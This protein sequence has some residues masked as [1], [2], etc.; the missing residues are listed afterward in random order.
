VNEISTDVCVVGGGPAGLM[1]TLLLLRSGLRVA[2]AEK[3]RSFDREY[4]GEILQPGGLRV[5]DQVGALAGAKARGGYEM[6]RFQLVNGDQPV[7]DIDY[8]R[9]P[10]PHDY[11]L[12]LPQ[13]HLL[14]ELT[15]H[16]ERLPGFEMLSG[17]R[18]SALTYDGSTVTGLVADNGADKVTVRARCVVGADGRYSKVRS[19]AGITNHR[20]DVFDRDVL[21]FRLPGPEKQTRVVRIFKS[22]TSPAM[23]YDSYPN[24]LQ[25][26]WTVPHG[27]YAEV[28]AQGIEAVREA[29]KESLPDYADLIEEH[30]TSLK[31][32]KLLDVF[33]ARAER[34]AGDGVLLIGDAA[35]AHSPL[36]A[37]GINLALQ[38]AVLAHPILIGALRDGDVSRG[39]LGEFERLRSRDIAHVM[40]FQELQAKGMF[41]HGGLADFMQPKISRVLM[42]TPMGHKITRF[43]TLGN[44]GIRVASELFTQPVLTGRNA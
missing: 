3:A 30:V 6:P 10:A 19:L 26:G 11:L 14:E 29:V 44:P 8:R 23:V 34:W 39:R 38:D 32:L 42:H 41:A 31:D 22:R 18:A 12:S 7:L 35:H 40:K 5:L 28:A 2:V 36:G 20:F 21:W 15:E 25:V 4:R 37:Q 27:G 1:L 43:V 9:L 33:S 16:C 13:R 17:Y 24:E